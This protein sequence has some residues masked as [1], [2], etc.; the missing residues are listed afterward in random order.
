MPLEIVPTCGLKDHV[1]AVF[2]L[3][4]T[5][6][7]KVAFWPPMSDALPGDKLTL[8]DPDP[9]PG[10]LGGINSK[11]TDA[12]SSGSATLV[13]VTLIVSWVAMLAGAVYFPFSITPTLGVTDQLTLLSANPST[14]AIN[15]ADWPAASVAGPEV[16]EM[17]TCLRAGTMGPR[18]CTSKTVAVAVLAGSATLVAEMVTFESST[19]EDGAVFT[20]LTLLPRLGFSDHRTW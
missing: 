13:A 14:T 16:I 4:V 11:G 9:V 15:C 7:R 6:G 2:E 19:K 1:T 5:A 3:P 17:L 10:L 20:P 18:G 12:V 8:T